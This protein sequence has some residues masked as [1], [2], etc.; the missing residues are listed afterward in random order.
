MGPLNGSASMP[1]DVTIDGGPPGDAAG[2]DVDADG[3]GK[4]DEP[5]M[6]QLIRQPGPIH[7]RLFEIVFRDPGAE[8]FVFTFG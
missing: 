6:Y 1:F 8:A 7:P 4:L 3:S 2:G 5:R